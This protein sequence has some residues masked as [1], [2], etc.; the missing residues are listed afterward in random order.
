MA[1]KTKDAND[2]AQTAAESASTRDSLFAD[3]KKAAQKGREDRGSA[4]R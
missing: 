2:R 3:L 1:E 4:S